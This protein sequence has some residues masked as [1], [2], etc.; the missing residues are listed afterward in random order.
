MSK[1]DLDEVFSFI[2]E[3]VENKEIKL[4]FY[5]GEPLLHQDLLRYA[6]DK[7]HTLWKYRISISVSSNATLLTPVL[8]D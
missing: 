7:A 6:I 8:I 5:G 1:Q 3:T 2:Q 4:A